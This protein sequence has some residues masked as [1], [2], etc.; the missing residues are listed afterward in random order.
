MSPSSPSTALSMA[1]M[2]RRHS[3]HAPEFIPASQQ[4]Q[5]S[6]VGSRIQSP[7]QESFY[8]QPQFQAPQ[9]YQNNF[10]SSYQGGGY[11]GGRG[12]FSRDGAGKGS[13][14]FRGR[15]RGRRRGGGF[16][17]PGNASWRGK[18]AP[19]QSGLGRGG[20]TEKTTH[21]RDMYAT[22][23]LREAARRNAALRLAGRGGGD[24][25]PERVNQYYAILPLEKNAG[26]GI[27][28]RTEVTMMS[29]KAVSSATGDL[30]TLRR[31]VGPPPAQSIQ[32]IRAGEMWKRVRHP[33]IV[34]LRE[35]F[36]TR[37]LSTKQSASLRATTE[38]IFAYDHLSQPESMFNIYL[39]EGRQFQLVGEATLWALATQLLSAVQAAHEAQLT[40]RSALSL[41]AVLLNG[42]N[43]VRI[44]DV[45][46]IDAFDQDQGDYLPNVSGGT[47]LPRL[48][49]FQ[50]EDL[51]SVGR[52]LLTLAVRSQPSLV[53][54]GV[55]VQGIGPS[56]DALQGGPYSPQLIHCIAILCAAGAPTST[57]TIQDVLRLLGPQLA[58][59]L[60]HVWTH[61][62]NM[63]NQVMRECDASRMFRL[64]TLLGFVN[65][66][67][68]VASDPNW[69][70]TGD[71]YLLKLFRDYVFHQ[72]DANG[73]PI[74]EMGHVLECLNRLDIGAEERIL[75]SSRD[76]KSLLIPTYADLRRCLQGALDELKTRRGVLR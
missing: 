23:G 15:G 71:R 74:M 22:E 12:G 45:G 41:T 10:S 27:Y 19:H 33:S 62:D 59:E 50:R 29:Y 2:L 43:R 42:N 64:M 6:Q 30:V 24:G 67:S 73:K 31:L 28:D 58:K 40:L 68:D 11:R 49:A 52:M 39:A 48:R 8:Q 18:G 70:E 56:L 75:L 65:E 72:V 46:I 38:V 3:P 66:R 17:L 57:L 60:G 16:A 35:V 69:S 14:E 5:R 13:Y 54:L 21:V 1:S 61:A 47:N 36:T 44:S 4:P 32:I 34:S 63:E 55:L 20:M 25:V 9:Q 26:M 7:P 51:A 53:R 76:G 37:E